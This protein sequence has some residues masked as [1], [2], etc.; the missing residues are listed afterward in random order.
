M[1]DRLSKLRA[2][3]GANTKKTRAG[4]GVGSGLG[5]TA[6]RGQK[7]QKARSTGRMG[8][9]AFQGGQT[10]IQRRLPKRGFRPLDKRDYAEVSVGSLEVFE[11][12]SVIDE[13][14]LREAGLVKGTWKGVKVLG[15]GELSRKLTLRINKI[16]KGALEKVVAVG[17]TVDLLADSPK[18]EES[19]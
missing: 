5:K 11:A 9:L 1:A 15:N 8:K 4:R 7:G 2:P 14:K 19:K 13:G 10:P 3:E 16:S 18:A 6:A 12:G 17:G